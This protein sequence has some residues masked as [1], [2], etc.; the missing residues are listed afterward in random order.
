M[1]KL[2]PIILLLA[3]VVAVALVII[4][5]RM[6]GIVALLLMIAGLAI[7]LFELYLYNKEYQ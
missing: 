7:I 3:F 1:K 5:Q 6:D 2:K 4:G